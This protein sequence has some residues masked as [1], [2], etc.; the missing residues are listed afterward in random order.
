LCRGFNVDQHTSLL[1][2]F[3]L[4]GAKGITA[5]RSIQSFQESMAK[6]LQD[7]RG[8]NKSADAVDALISSAF[9]QDAIVHLHLVC[10]R[11]AAAAKDAANDYIQLSNHGRYYI[12]QSIVL[13]MM[14][15]LT[16]YLLCSHSVDSPYGKLVSIHRECAGL[17]VIIHNGFR[18]MHSHLLGSAIKN[19]MFVIAFQNTFEIIIAYVD[20]LSA[21]G[22][23]LYQNR[24]YDVMSSA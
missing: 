1:N 10:T 18:R 9:F 4:V 6:E 24:V 14:I 5:L 17:F 22:S 8:K 2:A 19:P 13:T 11:C 3:A 12:H 15:V 7:T 23:V 20:S 21:L 16:I